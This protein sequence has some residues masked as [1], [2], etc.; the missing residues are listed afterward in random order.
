[1]AYEHVRGIRGR[2]GIGYAAVVCLGLATTTAGALPE[3][4]DTEY[5]CIIDPARIIELSSQVDGVIDKVLVERG[6]LFRKGQR[7][8]ELDTA[9]DRVNLE[10]ARQRAELEGQERAAAN[11][12]SFST[13]KASRALDLRARSL[14]AQQD[15]DEAVTERQLAEA[16]LL[17]AQENRRLA[18]TEMQRAQEL[19]HLKLMDAPFDGVVVNRYRHPGDVTSGAEDRKP[20]L[21]IARIDVLNVEVLVP[22]TDFGR[23]RVGDHGLVMPEL[24][25][26]TAQVG[27]VSIVDRVFDAASGTFGV[28][29]ELPN[30]DLALPAGVRCRVRFEASTIA[31]EP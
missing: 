6:E 24:P 1:M 4:A 30:P 16:E 5:D 17:S 19:L 18:Q 12:V 22:T 8:V 2:S 14:V 23:I 21:R 31:G 9:L 26:A 25:G 20:I 7:L 11:R 28:R 29:L 15:S 27:R 13:R 3:P 10:L